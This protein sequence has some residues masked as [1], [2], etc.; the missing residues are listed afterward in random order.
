MSDFRLNL[1]NINNLGKVKNFKTSLQLI[2]GRVK[3]S[4]DKN[5]LRN[6]VEIHR[7]ELNELDSVETTAA[8]ALL[9][10]GKMVERLLGDV[11]GRRSTGGT[12]L[13]IWD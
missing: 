4:K 13:R 3:Y 5:G 6:Y 9:G 12:V 7:Q 8:F 2:F 10:Q 11:K 1:I